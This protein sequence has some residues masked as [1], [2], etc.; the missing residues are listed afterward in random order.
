[1]VAHRLIRRY[2]ASVVGVV[3][4]AG[5]AVACELPPR[6]D[7]V[8]TQGNDA[9]DAA[10]GDGICEATAGAGDCTLR[11]AISEAN[12]LGAA[13]AALDIHVRLATDVTL[14]RAG[15][16][17]DSNYVGDL[18]LTTSLALDGDGFKIDAAGIDRIIDLRSGNLVID[19]TVFV[20]GNSRRDPGG[21]LRS[22]P[23]TSVS[24][25]RSSFALNH[26][27]AVGICLRADPVTSPEPP[28]NDCS[29]VLFQ[30]GGAIHSGG[31]LVVIASTF[32]RNLAINT[33]GCSRLS[34]GG[35]EACG[36]GFGGAIFADGATPLDVW[37]YR[38]KVEVAVRLLRQAATA[39]HFHAK[40]IE[41]S[42][43]EPDQFLLALDYDLIF[44]CIDD[45]PWPRSVLNTIAYTDLIPVLDGGIHVDAFEDGDGMR[46]AT[47]RSH[48]LRPGRPCMACNGQIDLGKIQ[49]DRD[50]LLDDAKYI[51]GLPPSNRPQSQNVAA[52][53][54]SATASLLAQFVSFVAAPA[55]IGD[56]GPLRYS[57]STH[58]LEHLKVTS[59]ETCPIERGTLAGDR[60]QVLLGEHEGARMEIAERKRA[61]GQR[62]IR[63]SRLLADLCVTKLAA[64]NRRLMARVEHR[65]DR[66]GSG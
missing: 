17:E 19:R 22:L 20:N 26:T 37:L 30:G 1:M 54:V 34:Y 63:W 13:A 6:H 7:F 43:C 28:S 64:I 24:V 38:S 36:L 11:A 14:S 58:D 15:A 16:A 18:D 50:G 25:A 31:T 44:C 49:V 42:V 27:E 9:V 33:L 45:H 53:S 61:A 59:R 12:A 10:P 5:V 41:G 47:W 8:V 66:F 29:P 56:P 39:S 32:A 60:R 62:V 40:A 2:V 23:G 3:V 55:G 57:L 35:V 51:A 4:V 65:M 46:N 52:L 21:A 48:V